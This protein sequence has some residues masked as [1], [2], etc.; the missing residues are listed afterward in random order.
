MAGLAGCFIIH[1]GSIYARNL[2][3]QA[4]VT[5]ES[6]V[7]FNVPAAALEAALSRMKEIQSLTIDDGIVT[8]KSGRLKSVIRLVESEP[9]GLP[10][11]PTEWLKTPPALVPA[12]KAAKEHCGEMGWQTCVRLMDERVTAFRSQSG[13]DIAVP[14]LVIKPSLIVPEVIDFLI[15]QGGSDYYA[16]QERAVCFQWEDGRWLRSQL[17]NAE[18]PEINIAGI[19]ENAGNEIPVKI[20]AEFRA[21]YADAAAMTDSVIM[22]TPEGFQGRTGDV[23]NSAVEF[24]IKG[25]PKDHA[26]YWQTKYLDP[27]MAQAVAWNPTTWPNPSYFEG[28]GLTGVIMGCSRW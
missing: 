5:F 9:P 24:K 3:M 12:L 4:G 20:T 1:N 16:S 14:G 22:M 11:M 23:A 25:L 7:D 18:M 17:Y 6:T 8:I 19:F 21:A 26:S 10:Q 2:A 28:P 15:A 13:I 27:V